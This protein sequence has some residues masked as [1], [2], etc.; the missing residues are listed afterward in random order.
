MIAANADRAVLGRV[1]GA[2][3]DRVADQLDRRLDREDPGAAPDEL[4]Q[5]VVLRGAAQRLDVV[6]PFLRHRE[7]H[8]DADRGG[9]V[10]RQRHRNLV[11]LDAIECDLEVTQRVDRHAN[12]ADLPAGQRIVR[13]DAYL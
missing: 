3:L 6:A 9:A 4:L 1:L 2:V 5:D 11:E 12:P 8:R 10:D 7:V 13:V